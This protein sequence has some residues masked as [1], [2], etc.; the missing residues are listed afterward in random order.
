MGTAHER[1]GKRPA[2]HPNPY[3]DPLVGGT[4]GDTTPPQGIN[5]RDYMS[6]VAYAPSERARWIQELYVA[7]RFRGEGVSTWLLTEASGRE[8]IALQVAR[9]STDTI[10][11]Y[12]HQ[13]LHPPRGV[14]KVYTQPSNPDTHML[15]ETDTLVATPGWAPDDPQR[16][17]NW[18]EIPPCAQSA[19]IS[20]LM[21]AHAYTRPQ[22]E[23][24]LTPRGMRYCVIDHLA[25]PGH[26]TGRRARKRPRPTPA[27][28]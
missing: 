9:A 8:P 11:K 22:A 12:A 3:S 23:E 27:N 14:P 17:Y 1:R 20:G 2:P 10:Q 24:S 6:F 19:M 5:D 7:E 25:D 28:H 21:H 4:S 18:D 13:G 15:L 16:Y 26:T